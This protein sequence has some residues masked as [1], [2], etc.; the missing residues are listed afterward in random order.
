[1]L[2]EQAEG[3]EEEAE[4]EEEPSAEFVQK[5]NLLLRTS[6]GRGFVSAVQRQVRDAASSPFLFRTSKRSSPP[7]IAPRTYSADAEGR[8][9]RVRAL[10]S[11]AAAVP[12]EGHGGLGLGSLGGADEASM[13]LRKIL[14]ALQLQ[15]Q[16][17]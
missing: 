4:E 15:Q 14:Y 16:Q 11:A 2:P 10:L 9:A 3:E 5:R 8:A 1:M 7:P 17:K 13:L 6:R 12:G